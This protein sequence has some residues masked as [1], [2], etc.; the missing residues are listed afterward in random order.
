M[1]ES[2]P[3]LSTPV[4]RREEDVRTHQRRN[5]LHTLLGL[6]ELAGQ[7]WATVTDRVRDP[8]VAAMLVGKSVMASERGVRL[9]VGE[10]SS[11][12]GCHDRA[13]DLVTI[14]GNL[15]DNAVD[16]LLGHRP[17]APDGPWIEVDLC[18]RGSVTELRVTDNGPG[19]P[20]ERRRWIFVEGA[21]TK[22]HADD[23]RRGLGLALVADLLRERGGTVTVGEREGGGA[24]FTVLLPATVPGGEGEAP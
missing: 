20:P 11:L 3:V 1:S 5:A 10:S 4:R 18:E 12:R 15:I 16:A 24:V 21:S 19:V 7:D 22:R 23:R 2:T 14:L 6:L 9:S 8:L 13:D 17:T